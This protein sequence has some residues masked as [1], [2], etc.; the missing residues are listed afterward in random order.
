[1]NFL[2]QFFPFSF[3]KKPDITSLVIVLILYLIASVVVSL[4]CWLF[5]AIG[6]GFLAWLI[7]TPASLYVTGGI[8]LTFLHYF[9]V[10]K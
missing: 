2:K 6:I 8:V 3:G 5:G 1:M 10:I 9:K 4:V 7:G